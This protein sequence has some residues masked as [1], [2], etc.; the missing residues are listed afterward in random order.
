MKCSCLRLCIY[1]FCHVL[2]FF[3][4]YS[5]YF[6]EVSFSRRFVHDCNEL[7]QSIPWY[8]QWIDSVQFYICNIKVVVFIT[9]LVWYFLCCELCRFAL[10][11]VCII[12]ICFF[13]VILFVIS[14]FIC[15]F[16][17]VVFY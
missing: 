6:W 15:S 14:M 4:L 11:R 17:M 16:I 10:R 12:A 5:D 2:L 13:P 3:E 1:C 7:C 8:F 9:I